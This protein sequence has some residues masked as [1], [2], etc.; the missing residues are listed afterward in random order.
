M[1]NRQHQYFCSGWSS[2]A[3]WFLLCVYDFGCVGCVFMSG[4]QQ[5][6]E[7]LSVI[8]RLTKA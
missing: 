7:A 4:Q 8:E 5:G 2:N 6:P 3:V 1:T